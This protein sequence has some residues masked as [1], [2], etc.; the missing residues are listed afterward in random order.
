MSNVS[1][2]LNWYNREVRLTY[3]DLT[4]TMRYRD[5]ADLMEKNGLTYDKTL[6]VMFNDE[7]WLE[8]DMTE[9]AN[10]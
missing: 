3:G 10:G 7:T 2:T 6:S 1:E 5:L 9:V 8:I 4:T